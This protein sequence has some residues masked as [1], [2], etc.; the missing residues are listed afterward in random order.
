MALVLSCALEVFNMTAFYMPL[1]SAFVGAILQELSHWYQLRS[2]LADATY[3]T[4]LRSKG[5]WIITA[6]MI[7]MSPVGV[8]F[9]FGDDISQY[10]LRDFF[11]FG[12]AFPMIFRSGVA[13]ISNAGGNVDLGNDD[14]EVSPIKT[15]FGLER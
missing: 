8:V 5:Y 7:I 1:L 10:K 15:Y 6:A 11:L 13:T 3:A 12:A 14:D 9:W 4:L 2:R